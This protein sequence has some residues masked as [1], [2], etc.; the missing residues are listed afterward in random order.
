M[1]LPTVQEKSQ[2]IFFMQPKAHKYKFMEM[3]KMVP[4]DLH[5]L[6]AFFEQCQAV[7]KVAGILE[8]IKAKK[9]P[10]EKKTTHLPIAHSRDSSYR[11][12][13]HKNWDYH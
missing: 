1:E 12:H 11:Q 13:H 7:D 8:K 9:Q 3:N 5:Q 6:I 2:Q 4:M 10:K